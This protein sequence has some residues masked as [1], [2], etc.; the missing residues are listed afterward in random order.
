MAIETA[1]GEN[2]NLEFNL[3]FNEEP[4]KSFQIRFYRIQLPNTNNH[5]RSRILDSLEGDK[6]LFQETDK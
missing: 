6:G 1:I 3:L 4:M 2:G 5:S